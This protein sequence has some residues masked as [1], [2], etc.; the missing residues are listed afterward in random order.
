MIID[1]INQEKED[2][3]SQNIKIVDGFYCNQRNIIEQVYRYYNSKFIDGDVDQDGDKK[4]FFNINRNPCKI[5]TKSIDFDTKDI[6]V[7]TASGGSSLKTWYFNIDLKQWMKKVGFGRTLNRIFAELPILGS[8]VLKIID[9]EP[10][11]VDLRNF[12]VEQSA[13]SL[14]QANYIIERHLYTPMEFEKIG[15]DLGWDFME[16]SLDEHRK[17]DEPYIAVYERYGQ[18]PEDGYKYKRTLFAD[19]GQDEENDHGETIG[20]P[21]YI[22]SDEEVEK[23]PYWE[24]HMEKISGRWLGVGIVEALFDTQVRMNEIANLQAKGSYWS[25]LRIFQTSDESVNQNLMSDV[26]NGAILNTNDRITQVDMADRSLAHFGEETQKWYGQRDELAITFDAN[27]GERSPSGTTLGEVQIISAQSG[28]YFEQIRENIALNIKEMLYD[29]IIPNFK[30]QNAGKHMVRLVGEDLDKLNALI[31]DQKTND[32]VIGMAIKGEVPTDAEYMLIKEGIT[33]KTKIGTEK[34][35]EIPTSFYQNLKYSIEVIITGESKNTAAITQTMFAALQ[36][37]TTDPTI[38]QDPA[39]K[40]IFFK[41]L[42]NAGVDPDSVI[43]QV[44]ESAVNQITQG[45]PQQRGGGGVSRPQMP[46]QQ[47]GTQETKI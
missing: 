42:E 47:M 18:D 32:R 35:K 6:R 17:S 29:I 27:R 33:Q 25:A 4:Y 30:R 46:G 19:V 45:Q 16:E 21:G 20:N 41:A 8:V 38:L 39:K 7:H 5:T 9:N 11:F 28:A 24:F 43:P 13:D 31:I 15:D 34:L 3:D 36:A 23:H 26:R 1:I 22:L 44:Q 10:V 37:I 40:K 14:D 2:F 12:I